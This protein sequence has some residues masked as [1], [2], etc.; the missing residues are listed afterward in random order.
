[1]KTTTHFTYSILALAVFLFSLPNVDGQQEEFKNVFPNVKAFA[2]PTF[3]ISEPTQLQTETFALLNASFPGEMLDPKFTTL[4][5]VS[6]SEAYL[7]YLGEA[8]PEV[9]RFK[10][11]AAFIERGGATRQ[12]YFPFFA[13]FLDFKKVED[14][15]EADHLAVHL[16][17]N[18]FWKSGARELQGEEFHD[19]YVFL[20][21]EVQSWLKKNGIEMFEAERSSSF[22]HFF[23][24]FV[25]TL[26]SL[27]GLVDANQEADAALVKTFYQRHGVNKGLLWLAIQE[28]L[29]FGR[30]LDGFT[31]MAVFRKWSEGE[32]S[33]TST[34]AA[35]AGKK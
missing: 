3:E 14:I 31:E 28:P 26:F 29:L 9:P 15:P 24:S 34:E 10:T 19:P 16:L 33:D 8:Y 32:P 2:T 1:M 6:T 5:A 21:P 18:S 4:R 17:A 20:Q 12:R 23:Q 27:R 30:I 25:G 35:P 11:L 22:Q 13:V 7:T